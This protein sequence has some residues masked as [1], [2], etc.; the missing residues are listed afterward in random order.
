MDHVL[1]LIEELEPRHLAVRQMQDAGVK[2]D[3][4][5]YSYDKTLP[6]LSPDTLRRVAALGLEI[7]MDHYEKDA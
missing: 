5:C 6:D 2:A 3:I 1:W 4:F 7:E